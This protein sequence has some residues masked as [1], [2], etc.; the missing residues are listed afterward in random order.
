MTDEEDFEINANKLFY[1]FQN[2]AAE[3][4]IYRYLGESEG[5]FLPHFFPSAPQVIANCLCLIKAHY[6]Y[7]SY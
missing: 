5:V 1:R 3:Q 7:L 4:G 2:F 6:L